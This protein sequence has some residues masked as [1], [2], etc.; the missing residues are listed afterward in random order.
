MAKLTVVIDRQAVKEAVVNS[1]GTKKAIQD[2]CSKINDRANALAAGYKTGI[3]HEYNSKT[4]KNPGHGKWHEHGAKTEEIGGTQARY[5]SSV[6]KYP[7]AVIG[8]VYTSNYA[9]QKENMQHNT[10]LKSI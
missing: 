7:T 10:L 9:A 4:A 8:I 1:D 2:C 3:W 6:R 5:K